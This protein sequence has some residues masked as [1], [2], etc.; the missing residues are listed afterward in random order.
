MERGRSSGA[1]RPSRQQSQDRRGRE[2]GQEPRR[3]REP[4]RSRSR[5]GRSRDPFTQREPAG[6]AMGRVMDTKAKA[7]MP[8]E[9]P[10]KNPRQPR[11]RPP[12]MAPER[13]YPPPS[14]GIPQGQGCYY[15]ESPNFAAKC[16]GGATHVI[17]TCD[18][19][20]LIYTCEV[21]GD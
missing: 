18:K 10:R 15:E 7:H 2:D 17:Q 20:R 6:H 5:R 8:V 19:G 21:C 9:P 3:G 1:P 12:S 14:Q 4:T 13:E 16:M 11:G